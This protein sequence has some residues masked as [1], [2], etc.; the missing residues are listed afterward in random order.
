MKQDVI[1][2]FIISKTDT[3]R[4]VFI[5]Y[6]ALVFITAGLVSYFE[7]LTY[8]DSLWLTFV[9]AM[10]I[11]YGDMFPKTIEGRVTIMVMAHIVILV[12]IPL[13]VV[14]LLGLVVKDRNAFTHEEQEE[15]KACLRKLQEEVTEK[16][17]QAEADQIMDVKA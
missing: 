12:I 7:S 13:I 2:N 3:L 15:L 5:Y 10:T 17:T 9:S 11:G 4:E 1:A 8:L 16:A 6:F 14:R